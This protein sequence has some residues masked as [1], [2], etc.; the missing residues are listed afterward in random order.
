MVLGFA[1]R[2]HMERVQDELEDPR[3]GRDVHGAFQKALG[4]PCE[5]RLV[6]E[7]NG[8]SALQAGP[9]GHLVRAAMSLGGT[10]VQEENQPQDKEAPD[11][12]STDA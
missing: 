8:P 1:H 7:G 10:I 12:Q 9:S 4:A 3:C 5:I 11:V 6:C 2:S